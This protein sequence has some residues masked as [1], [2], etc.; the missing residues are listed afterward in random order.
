MR[1]VFDVQTSESEQMQSDIN[2]I[3]GNKTTNV[4]VLSCKNSGRIKSDLNDI[5]IKKMV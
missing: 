4:M 5:S 3:L 2:M 1:N